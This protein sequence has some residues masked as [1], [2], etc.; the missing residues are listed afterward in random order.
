MP[1]AATSLDLA[2]SAYVVQYLARDICGLTSPQEQE[3]AF[4]LANVWFAGQIIAADQQ[5]AYGMIENASGTPGS[6]AD[7]LMPG[8]NPIGRPGSDPGIRELTGDDASAR[9]FFDELVRIT[10]PPPTE[11]GT[12]PGVRYA[13]PGGGFL[14]FRTEAS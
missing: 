11:A 10:G 8:G 4:H 1:Y 6:A 2:G 14:G 12:Y 5:F 3:A 13:V 7:M 9:E